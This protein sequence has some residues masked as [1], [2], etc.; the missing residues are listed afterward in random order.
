MFHLP[1]DGDG[2]RNPELFYFCHA[3]I[4]SPS[5][6]PAYKNNKPLCVGIERINGALKILMLA[7]RERVPSLGD[8][9]RGFW[10]I[11]YIFNSDTVQ[12]PLYGVILIYSLASLGENG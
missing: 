6:V 12:K 3:H 1:S 9:R 8:T 4:P 2:F 7:Y 5:L 11:F 10:L